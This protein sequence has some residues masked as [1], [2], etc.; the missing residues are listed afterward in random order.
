MSVTADDRNAVLDPA[1]QHH[2]LPYSPITGGY[3][4]GT[5]IIPNLVHCGVGEN[6]DALL[7]APISGPDKNNLLRMCQE[8]SVTGQKPFINCKAP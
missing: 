4:Q 3:L 2:R 5:V 8:N 7:S 6:L 1:Q